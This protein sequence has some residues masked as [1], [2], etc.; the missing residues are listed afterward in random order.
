MSKD[1]STFQAEKPAHAKAEK[2]E[3]NLFHAGWG[4]T[5]VKGIGKLN[6]RWRRQG[7][8]EKG[9]TLGSSELRLRAGLPPEP[10]RGSQGQK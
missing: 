7:W 2:N 8:T 5:Q 3:P 6:G 1:R 9:W 4:E 10:S